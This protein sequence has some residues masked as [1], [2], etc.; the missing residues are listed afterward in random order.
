MLYVPCE[1]NAE[2]AEK[3]KSQLKT[4]LLASLG[5]RYD[6]PPTTTT[7]T[8]THTHISSVGGRRNIGQRTVHR[9]FNSDFGNFILKRHQTKHNF[10]MLL[11]KWKSSYASWG[12]SKNASNIF[13]SYNKADGNEDWKIRKSSQRRWIFYFRDIFHWRNREDKLCKISGKNLKYRGKQN[14]LKMAMT[15]RSSDW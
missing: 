6:P 11:I 1:C 7:N 13:K 5:R 9:I 2:P 10:E 4:T 14:T 12:Q 8:H 15:I 3:L